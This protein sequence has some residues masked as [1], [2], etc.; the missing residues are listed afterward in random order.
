MILRFVKSIIKFFKRFLAVVIAAVIWETLPRTGFID[1]YTL[2]PFSSVV[3]KLVEM[4][5]SLELQ[6]HFGISFERMFFGFALS[7]IVAIPLGFLVGWSERLERI[8]DP[9]MQL[10]RNTPSLAL[11]PLFI[12][13][14]GFSEFS[15]AG[16]IFWGAVW[17]ALFSTIE[18]VK[19]V[20]AVLIKA[21][22][23]MGAGK[24]V[25][26]FKVILPSAFPAIFTGIRLSA[27]RSVIILVAAEMLGADSGLGHLIFFAENHFE[28]EKMYTGIIAL[29]IMGVA[30]N[31][32]LVAVERKITKWRQEP[33]EA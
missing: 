19:N 8:L 7:I 11:Y 13:V 33:G 24:I 5:L 12:L 22:R 10:S 25:L 21:T 15:K 20:D 16:I 1:A 4:L 30:V 14:L 23:S 29:I 26:F 28:T 17:P 32:T 6:M 27:S 9:L 31:Y 18:G 2:P 3:K